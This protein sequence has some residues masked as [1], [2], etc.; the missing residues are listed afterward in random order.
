MNIL[1][2]HM[3]YSLGIEL[4]VLRNNNSHLLCIWNSAYKYIYFIL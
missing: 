4:E 2:I 3:F 1:K